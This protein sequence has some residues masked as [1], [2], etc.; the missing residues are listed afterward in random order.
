MDNLHIIE[1][2]NNLV[3]ERYTIDPITGLKEGKYESWYLNGNK[4]IKCWYKQ[5]L[6]H[7]KYKSWYY[8]GQPITVCNYLNGELYGK[9]ECWGPDGSKLSE[10]FCV[11]SKLK[12]IMYIKGFKQSEYNYINGKMNGV[13]KHWHK[14]GKLQSLCNYNDDILNGIYQRW[15]INGVKVEESFYKNGTRIDIPN[16]NKKFE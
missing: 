7:D 3:K 10:S 1:N 12:C 9:D 11:G 8:D 4:N 16:T 14:N 5:G 6:L 13:C 15:D 2:E